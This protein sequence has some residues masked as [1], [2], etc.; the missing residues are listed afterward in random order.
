VG[1]CGSFASLSVRY[2]CVCVCVCVWLFTHAHDAVR[3][4]VVCVSA[5]FGRGG[6]DGNKWR[7][8]SFPPSDAHGLGRAPPMCFFFFLLQPTHRYFRG[9]G[10]HSIGP[11]ARWLLFSFT[12][13]PG[14]R[15]LQT[16]LVTT[17]A[18]AAAAHQV[19][20]TSRLE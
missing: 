5:S 3:E 12:T 8:G 9:I 19:S 4:E 7:A 20:T 13:S 15:M 17:A 11:L 6:I 1:D 10:S 16:K 18:A 14:E 2:V